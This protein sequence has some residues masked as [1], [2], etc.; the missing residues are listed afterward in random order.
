ML[1]VISI[2]AIL[3]AISLNVVKGV[4]ERSAVGLAKAELA[5]LSQ[6]LEMYK[7]QYGDYPQTGGATNASLSSTTASA[8]DAQGILFNALTG[9]RGPLPAETK[10]DGKAYVD[11][12][13]FVLQ[14]PTTMPASGANTVAN[15]FVDPWGNRYLYY[16]KTGTSAQWNTTPSYVL[17]SVGMDDAP[18]GVDTAPTVTTA[19]VV[20]PN[21]TYGDN[22]IY[23]NK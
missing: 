4:K 15:A 2:I 8:T 11:L 23:A 21:T 18:T 9:K 17:L 16:Y 20:T 10:I 1:T 13:R 22:D 3:S 6:A 12:A 7:L 14:S 5:A 19:G